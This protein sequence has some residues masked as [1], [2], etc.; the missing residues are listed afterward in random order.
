MFAPSKLVGIHLPL[1]FLPVYHLLLAKHR[2]HGRYQ[3]LY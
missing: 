2:N 1:S 3:L